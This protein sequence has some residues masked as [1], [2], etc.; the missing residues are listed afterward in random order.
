[1]FPFRAETTDFFLFSEVLRPSL[2]STQHRMLWVPRALSPSHKAAGASNCPLT[3]ISCRLRM[4]GAIPP[5][6]AFMGCT[7]TTCTRKDM[8]STTQVPKMYFVRSVT[9]INTAKN[10]RTTPDVRIWKLI[11][12][13]IEFL[14]A[15]IKGWIMTEVWKVIPRKRNVVEINGYVL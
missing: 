2:G 15:D 8:W 13:Q 9:V 5:P 7:R 10:L 14:T 4:S 12:L 1:M 11:T 3:I 6:Y